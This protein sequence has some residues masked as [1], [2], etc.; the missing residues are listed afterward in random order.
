VT[1][2][3]FDTFIHEKEYLDRVSINTIRSYRD[4]FKALERY[5]N[6][7]LTSA[8]AKAFVIACVEAGLSPRTVNSWASAI[9]SFFTW[10]HANNHLP[11]RHRVPLQKTA[12]RVLLTYTPDEVS[13]IVNHKPKSRTGKRIMAILHLLIDTGCRI[14]EAL[15]LTRDR[16]DLDNLLVTLQGKGN[17]ERRVPISLTCRASL[18]RCLSSHPHPLVFSTRDGHKLSYNNIRRDFRV[19][20]RACKVEKS[21][22]SFHAFRRY[23]GKQYLRNGGSA[24]YLQRV[25]GHTSLAMVNRYVEADDDDLSLAH[26]RLSPLEAARSKR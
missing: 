13:R 17:K 16:V 2:S 4:A 20:L 25:F 14:N 6:H 3:L 26:K 19:I 1:N 10:A 23:F 8:G 11:E 15:T 12:K 18:F 5:G 9:N 22:G 7:P 24:P 21:E